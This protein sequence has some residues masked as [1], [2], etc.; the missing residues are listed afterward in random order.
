[1][2]H[3]AND[4]EDLSP[5]LYEELSRMLKDCLESHGD[6]H[7]SS[8]GDL[9][10]GP[11]PLP[12]RVLDVSSHE[13]IKVSESHGERADYAALSHRWGPPTTAK[14]LLKK[15]NLNELRNGVPLCTLPKTYRDAVRFTKGMGLRYLWIDS[16]CILQDNR[17]DWLQEGEKMADVYSNALFT[18]S[19]TTAVGDSSGIF[20]R[21]YEQTTALYADSVSD[22]QNRV[23]LRGCYTHKQCTKSLEDGEMTR[24]GWIFQEALLSH[25]LIHF[26]SDCCIVWECRAN[27]RTDDGTNLEHKYSKFGTTRQKNWSECLNAAARLTKLLHTAM[28]INIPREESSH[29]LAEQASPRQHTST[30]IA[31]QRH[32]SGIIKDYTSR[33]L[34]VNDDRLHAISGTIEFVKKLTGFANVGGLWIPTLPYELFWLSRFKPNANVSDGE[35][36]S[37]ERLYRAPSWS[38]VSVKHPITYDSVHS[39]SARIE[40]NI[41]FEIFEIRMESL[42][43]A[44]PSE[45]RHS[46]LIVSVDLQQASLVKPTHTFRDSEFRS[47]D[48]MRDIPHNVDELERLPNVLRMRPKIRRGSPPFFDLGLVIID[49]PQELFRQLIGYQEASLSGSMP[50]GRQVHHVLSSIAGQDVYCFKVYCHNL[51]NA[52]YL[53]QKKSW[54]PYY[55]VLVMRK[56]ENNQFQRIGAGYVPERGWFSSVKKTEITMI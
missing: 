32:W 45:A 56:M 27:F 10:K 13:R 7:H 26:P 1:M 39:I 41:D 14:L 4:S 54:I 55:R 36:L 17:Q 2:R 25:R 40:S 24:R 37:K 35:N 46:S 18:I 11:P 52:T 42:P 31:F 19:A 23:Y 6:C 38:W 20:I 28:D 16:L 22:K 48:S 51:R 8:L 47:W 44:Q 12:T 34:T 5:Q 3:R 29:A 9:G 15:S 53:D 50:N 43:S 21:K 49:D 30:R 33:H